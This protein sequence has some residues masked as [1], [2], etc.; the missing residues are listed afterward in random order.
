ML[1]MRRCKARV[2]AYQNKDDVGID[3]ASFDIFNM[4]CELKLLVRTMVPIKDL[5]SCKKLAE[6]SAEDVVSKAKNLVKNDIVKAGVGALLL[7]FKI[8]DVVKIEDVRSY[9]NDRLTQLNSEILAKHENPSPIE[10]YLLDKFHAE[11][12]YCN[13][14]L[15]NAGIGIADE[16]RGLVEIGKRHIEKYEN[17]RK[18]SQQFSA[19]QGTLIRSI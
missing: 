15:F 2:A 16:M 12:G 10:Q 11:I 13:L 1:G 8:D 4:L 7:G 14:A 19:D 3:N 18:T 6:L 9:Y 5:P 17:M